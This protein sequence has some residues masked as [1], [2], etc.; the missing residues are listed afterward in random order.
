MVYQK[1]YM[2]MNHGMKSREADRRYLGR[3]FLFGIYGCSDMPY[4]NTPDYPKVKDIY[5][6]Y[7]PI[8]RE[9]VPL[10][11]EPITQARVL[12]KGVL[13]E[14]FGKGKKV[15]FSLY[16]DTGDATAADLEVDCRALNMAAD[17][18]KVTDPVSDKKLEVSKDGGK[19]VIHGIALSKDGIGVVKI[20]L[21]GK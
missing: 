9:M 15:F 13:T 6:T 4:F 21:A 7:L 17:G 16:R 2:S 18:V 20:G 3:C 5:D 11:W 10:G 8:Q 14:R 1:P 12:T 19:I